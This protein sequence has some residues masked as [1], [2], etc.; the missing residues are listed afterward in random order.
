MFKYKHISICYSNWSYVTVWVCRSL[1]FQY[2]DQSKPERVQF[3]HFM[4]MYYIGKDWPIFHVGQG[5]QPGTRQI[6]EVGILGYQ[7]RL[8][9]NFIWKRFSHKF[10][11][12]CRI[13]N[14][15]WPE[16]ILRVRMVRPHLLIPWSVTALNVPL[17]LCANR[18]QWGIHQI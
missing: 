6:F 3:I 12:L 11:F 5:C 1:R 7:N 8:K 18:Q 2:R 14:S 9:R 17:P 13:I 16:K 10:S 15:E 4:Y